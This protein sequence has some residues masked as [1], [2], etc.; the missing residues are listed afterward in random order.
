MD[1]AGANFQI[2]IVPES[3]RVKRDREALGIIFC[4]CDGR[5]FPCEGWNDF[6]L[7]V[8]EWWV[9]AIVRLLS[10][11]HSS[12][13]LLFME[14]PFEIRI[15]RLDESLHIRCLDRRQRQ[16]SVT[17][18]TTAEELKAA[19]VTG[20]NSLRESLQNNPSLRDDVDRL[21][22]KVKELT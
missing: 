1:S 22:R 15:E 17:G 6:V 3:I 5:A 9:D 8:F 10:S 7:V 11:N 4:V 13:D 12:A 2:I 19:L 20:V 18:T 16:P 21:A 14:G